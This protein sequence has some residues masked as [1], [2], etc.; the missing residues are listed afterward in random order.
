MMRL[1]DLAKLVATL[2]PDGSLPAETFEALVEVAQGA[3]QD[4]AVAPVRAR[5][6]ANCQLVGLA[7][8]LAIMSPAGFVSRETIARMVKAA[9]SC[10]QVRPAATT[11]CL[12]RQPEGLC[13]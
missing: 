5:L 4:L 13:A 11:W 10:G 2:D 6:S 9:R 1:I 8:S 7:Q 12:E 3:L